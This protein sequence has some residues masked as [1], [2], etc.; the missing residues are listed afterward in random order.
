[1]FTSRGA[2]NG[3]TT[4]SC[5]LSESGWW[6]AHNN[7]LLVC[8][9][10]GQAAHAIERAAAMATTSQIAAGFAELGSPES[11]GS[12]TSTRSLTS[13]RSCGA[14]VAEYAARTAYVLA[15]LDEYLQPGCGF[16][17]HAN[18]L[19]SEIIAALNVGATLDVAARN[20]FESAARLGGTLQMIP[21]SWWHDRPPTEMASP[22]EMTGIGLHHAAHFLDSARQLTGG[23][24]APSDVLADLRQG[25]AHPWKPGGP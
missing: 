6:A 9:G 19:R 21:D 4:S 11:T 3:T 10:C 5:R 13:V 25:S 23:R 18:P 20:L 12:L 8:T 14:A 1:M 7:G 16:A 17:W 2:G 15:C 24:Q 22:A